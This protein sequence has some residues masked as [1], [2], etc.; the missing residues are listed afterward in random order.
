MSKK[1]KTASGSLTWKHIIGYGAGDCGGVITLVIFGYVTRYVTNVLNISYGTLSALLL[2]WNAWD[3]INDPLV[4]SLMDKAFVKQTDHT[5]DKFRPWIKWSIPLIVLGLLAFFSVPGY[6]SGMTQVI[7]LFLLKI[8]YEW[9]YTMMNI[10]MGSL[11]GVIATDDTE[12]ATLSSARGMGSTIGIMFTSAVIP[13]VLSKFGEN[14]KGYFYAAVICAVLGGVLIWIHYSWTE[15]RN[16]LAKMVTDEDGET[17][18][19]KYSDIFE[20]FK[21]NRAYVALCIHSIAVT[22]GQT[23]SSTTGSYILADV[24]GD[25]GLGTISG[26]LSQ[27]ISVVALLI[28]PKLSEK[29]GGT[30]KMIEYALMGGSLILFGLYFY[31]NNFTLT[32]VQYVLISSLGIGLINLSVQMQWGLVSESIDYNEFLTGKRT[33]GAIYGTFSLTRRVGQTIAQSLAV[34]LIG[35][36]GYDAALGSNQTPAT[37]SGLQMMNM[38]IP[39]IFGIVS[40]ICFRFIW[41]IDDELRAEINEWKHEKLLAAE[42]SR[43]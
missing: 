39:A 27:A 1:T 36:I 11:L 3:M 16:I 8:V 18:E 22:F 9:G 38:F 31:M 24:F 43:Q 20:V 19:V 33:E 5:K 13:Q 40:W 14:L 42:K 6:L 23:L 15:E 7:V 35:V 29:I 37:V 10:A 17:E 25:I 28:A 4:G 2:V 34:Y 21:K 30:S 32:G 12:R 26:I 41:N